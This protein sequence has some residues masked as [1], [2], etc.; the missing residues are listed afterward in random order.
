MSHSTVTALRSSFA[1]R[2]AARQA[3]KRLAS[4]LAAYSSPADRLEL[5]LILG[6]HSAEETA[7]VDAVL[8]RLATAAA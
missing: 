5:D 3:R 1:S 4:E 2:R 8:N 6:R 7:E